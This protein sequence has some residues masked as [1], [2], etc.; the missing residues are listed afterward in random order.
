M[1]SLMP[2]PGKGKEFAAS[3]PG[4]RRRAPPQD[5]V[6]G[7][8]HGEVAPPAPP[9]CGMPGKGSLRAVPFRGAGWGRGQGGAPTPNSEGPLLPSST[10]LAEQERCHYGRAGRP[11]LPGAEERAVRA[12]RKGARNP[13]GAR[14]RQ[15]RNVIRHLKK[16]RD[17]Y[18]SKRGSVQ[19]RPRRVFD[20][21]K[22]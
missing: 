15:P 17:S 9:P 14:V 8:S 18:R 2:H 5:R 6:L 20:V 1:R 16:S 3:R 22:R 4:S 7:A 10:P 21:S 13:R 11:P 19:L 12:I